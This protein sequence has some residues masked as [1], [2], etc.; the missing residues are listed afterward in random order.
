MLSHLS[1]VQLFATLW[2]VA[3]QAPL[4]VGFSR[5][6]YW[7]GLPCPPPG[8]LPNTG[9][10]PESLTSPALAGRIFTTSTTWESHVCPFWFLK[11]HTPF[12]HLQG[13]TTSG[14]AYLFQVLLR[15]NVSPYPARL[16]LPGS[17]SLSLLPPSPP[18][19]STSFYYLDLGLSSYA[20]HFLRK[21]FMNLLI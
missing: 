7:S 11:I 19:I 13:L 5:Q 8:Y 21:A 20:Q 1:R 9:I 3:C 16:A 15:T 17:R 14:S 4:S 2:T 18:T 10:E 12:H 6:E